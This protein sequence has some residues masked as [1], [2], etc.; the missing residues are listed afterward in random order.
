MDLIFLLPLK[1]R[2]IQTE[3]EKSIKNAVFWW[4]PVRFLQSLV[5]FAIHQPCRPGW[6]GYAFFYLDSPRHLSD[7]AHIHVFISRMFNQGIIIGYASA[8]RDKYQP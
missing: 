8:K 6:A 5:S 2:I 7:Y 3:Q 1:D 4:C